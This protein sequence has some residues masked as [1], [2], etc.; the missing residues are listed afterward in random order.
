MT[1]IEP[2]SGYSGKLSRIP[3]VGTC[4]FLGLEPENVDPSNFTSSYGLIK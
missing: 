3:I 2:E 4:R 1:M